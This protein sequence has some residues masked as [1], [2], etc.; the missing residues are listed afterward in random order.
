MEDKKPPWNWPIEIFVHKAVYRYLCL[1][2]VYMG[3]SQ[4]G[5]GPPHNTSIIP[6]YHIVHNGIEDIIISH[7]FA[8]CVPLRSDNCVCRGEYC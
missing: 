4:W 3:I 7:G 5:Q 2:N 6:D 1:F 8:P